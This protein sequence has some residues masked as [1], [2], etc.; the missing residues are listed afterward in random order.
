MRDPGRRPGHGEDRREG[1]AW[2]PDGIEQQRGVHLDI[3]LQTA[4][5]LAALERRDGGALDPLGEGEAGTVRIEP[6]QGGP[7]HVGA[8]IAQPEHAM[9]EAHQALAGRELAF[10]GRLDIVAVLRDVVEQVERQ[11]GCTAVQ[12]AGECAV[13]T[14]HGR[15]QR[16]AGRDDD[17]RR[18]GRSAEPIV[19]DGRD[20]GIE[21]LREAFLDRSA[22]DHAQ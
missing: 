19:D 4:A 15:R 17:A 7:Q 22:G 18:E 3:G 11:S 21:R 20:I 6:Q 14:D 5:G 9:A 10:K 16:G 13:G 1:G 2:Q 12:R 8:W